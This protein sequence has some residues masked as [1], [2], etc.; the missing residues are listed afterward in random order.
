MQ[1]TCSSELLCDWCKRRLSPENKQRRDT[2]WH[3]R[4]MAG[5]SA[6]LSPGVAAPEPPQRR[7]DR[8]Q[9]PGGRG[10]GGP[11]Q[12]AGSW[13]A[14][15]RWSRAGGGHLV[16]EGQVV[17]G[18]L[19]AAG[20]VEDVAQRRL[21]LRQ[22]LPHHRRVPQNPHRRAHHLLRPI[23]VA[24]PTITFGSAHHHIRVCIC[25][26]GAVSPWQVI[27]Q[28]T[29]RRSCRLPRGTTGQGLPKASEAEPHMA[30]VCTSQ[31]T[32]FPSEWEYRMPRWQKPQRYYKFPPRTRSACRLQ[33]PP[34]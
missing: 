29:R 23:H 3:R 2:D 20:A 16:G 14:R 15:D 13:W 8:G 12:G 33:G 34:G 21:R 10:T 30:Y 31:A 9:T 19:G 7:Q 32:Q 27:N 18:V 1:T 6:S 25:R 11:G 22:G 4:P 26:R 24:V 17:Q 28:C 5:T